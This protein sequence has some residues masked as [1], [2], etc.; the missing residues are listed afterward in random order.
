M[1]RMACVRTHTLRN[2]RSVCIIHLT[3]YCIPRPTPEVFAEHF[4]AKVTH[5]VIMVFVCQMEN[6]EIAT[7]D[8]GWN[9]AH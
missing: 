6:D 5:W 3:Q 2:S 1:V 7:S 9:N 8:D 4:R